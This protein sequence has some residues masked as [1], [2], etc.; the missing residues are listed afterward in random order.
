GG[1]GGAPRARGR[2][3]GW[4]RAPPPPPPLEGRSACL[5][6][7]VLRLRPRD[8]HSARGLGV[9]RAPLPGR[10][11]LTHRRSP[12]PG[13]PPPP[14]APRVVLRPGGGRPPPSRRAAAPGGRPAPARHAWPDPP[15]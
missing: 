15:D 1:V 4:A 11:R 7:A 5:R 3:K 12:D 8:V 10:V 2:G 9:T 6:R 14:R 13:P